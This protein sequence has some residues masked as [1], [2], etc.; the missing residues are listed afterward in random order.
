M[1][2]AGSRNQDASDDKIVEHRRAHFLAACVVRRFV[3]F[4]M[5]GMAT[6]AWLASRFR[7][8]A[9][10]VATVSALAPE[11]PHL[12]ISYYDVAAFRPDTIRSE[13]DADGPIDEAGARFDSLTR[14]HYSW[15]WRAGPGG[16]CGTPSAQIDFNAEMILPRLTNE[17]KL[18]APTWRAWR[19][20]LDALVRHEIG[21]VRI[22][23]AVKDELANAIRH[24]SCAEANAIGHHILDRV[25]QRD[26]DYDRLTL[27][28]MLNGAVFP[29]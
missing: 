8:P 27:H 29:A 13:L 11:V 6:I 19:R 25:R 15:T 2:P 12:N 23:Y 21:H 1:Q 4:A 18:D 5:L 7:E 3:I 16:A 17:A 10:P 28:G 26:A 20:Y 24:A 14:W 9:Y 22:A